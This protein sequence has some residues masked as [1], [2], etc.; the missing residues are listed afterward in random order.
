[1]PAT[2]RPS[3]TQTRGRIGGLTV[4]AVRGP[5]HMADIG[6]LGQTG[7]DRRLA[8]QAGLVPGSPDYRARLESAR[9]AHFIRLAEARWS[10]KPRVR[11]TPH[12]TRAE[13]TKAATR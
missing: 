13:E 8:A 4:A 10:T 7:L 2:R 3:T 11:D 1:V 9:K 5:E 6:R 12:G